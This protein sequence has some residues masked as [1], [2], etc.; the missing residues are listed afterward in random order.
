MRIR[1]LLLAIPL[2]LMPLSVMAQSPQTPAPA[3]GQAAGAAAEADEDAYPTTYGSLDFGVRATR[4]SGDLAR[5]ERYRDMGDGLFLERGRYSTQPRGWQLDFGTD[6]L[7]RRDQRFTGS[8]VKPGQFKAYAQWDQ[9]PMLM[10]RTTR[11]LFTETARGVLEI[12]NGIQAASQASP[13]ALGTFLNQ[14]RQFDLKTRRHVFEGGAKYIGNKDAKNGFTIS[15][16]VRQIDREGSIPFGGSFGHSNVVETLAPVQHSTTDFGSSAEWV[17]G[18]LLVRGGYNGSWFRNDVTSLTFDNPWRV[19]DAVSAGSRGRL[20]LAPDNSLIGINGLVSYKLPYRSRASVYASAST[21]RDGGAALLPFT[22]NTAVVSPTLD[23]ATT[24][25]KANISSVNLAFVSRPT[26]AVDIDLRFR[27]YDYDNKTPEFTVLQRSAYDNGIQNVTNAALRHTEPFGVKRETFDGDVRLSPMAV[28]SAGVGFTH[29]GEERTHRI[30]ERTNNNVVRFTVD[31]TRNRWVTVRSKYE[32]S[33][34]R[35]EGDAREIADELFAIGEQPGMRH[36]D[37]AERNR[38]RGTILVSVMP[39]DTL[40]IN[41]SIAG[42]KDDYQQSLFG[43]RDNSHRVYSAGLEYSPSEYVAAGI[44]FSDERYKALSRSRQASPA[45]SAQFFDESRNW[46]TDTTDTA[47]SVIAHLDL[48]QIVRD[49]DVMLSMDH[50]RTRGVFDYI[51]GAVADRT[52]PEETPNLPSTLPVPNQLPPAKTG[53]TRA[54]FDLVYTLTERWGV[55]FS[56]W[57][58]KYTVTDFSLDAEALAV[59]NPANALLLGYTYAP[60]TATTVWGRMI[61]KF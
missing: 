30:F 36:F 12:D 42:G 60:Y 53:L 29:E 40:V 51:T 35:G 6:H 13:S 43:L 52:L 31:S 57:F 33:Q 44:S 58:E 59:T 8:F 14:A 39:K 24:N 7:G 4:S 3:P 11:T 55:G 2:M 21:L 45:P 23:R 9:I 25:G 47:K 19:T 34:K 26:R 48:F 5:Y 50:S 41:G 1:T 18:N 49:V 16:N 27:T 38:S 15:M 28:F 54:T 20:A 22:V 46:A 56:T 17:E 10:S 32:Y 37:I 61:Y